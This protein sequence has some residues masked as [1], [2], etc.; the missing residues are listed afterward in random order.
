MTK[1][2]LEQIIKKKIKKVDLLKKSL[3]TNKISTNTTKNFPNNL[4]I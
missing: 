1:N 3:K 4:I 2:I